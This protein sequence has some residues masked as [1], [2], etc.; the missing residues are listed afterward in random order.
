MDIL[1]A[2]I[3]KQRVQNSTAL[4]GRTIRT[5]P[6]SLCI[7]NINVLFTLLDSKYGSRKHNLSICYENFFCELSFFELYKSRHSSTRKTICHPLE[8]RVTFLSVMQVAAGIPHTF[9]VQIFQL[10]NPPPSPVF[11]LSLKQ[12]NEELYPFSYSLL[13]LSCLLLQCRLR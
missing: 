2:T 9:S 13:P 4:G 11:I 6:R 8:T 12:N 1:P 3:W 10:Q 7:S 5:C